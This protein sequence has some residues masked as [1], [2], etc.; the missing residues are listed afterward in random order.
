MEIFY[1]ADSVRLPVDFVSEEQIEFNQNLND[2]GDSE[3]E[4][5]NFFPE[6]IQIVSELEFIKHEIETNY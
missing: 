5:F 3:I 4:V 6:H 2:W 1:P